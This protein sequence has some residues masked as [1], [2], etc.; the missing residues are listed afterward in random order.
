MTII[1]E[2][3]RGFVKS[4]SPGK[5]STI[6]PIKR[7][8][9][10]GKRG[11][12]VFE[13]GMSGGVLMASPRESKGSTKTVVATHTES[14]ASTSSPQE[15]PPIRPPGVPRHHRRRQGSSALSEKANHI[16]PRGPRRRSF[17]PADRQGKTHCCLQE[18]Q[19]S[20]NRHIK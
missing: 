3:L 1:A 18:W 5:T 4:D 10:L 8:R 2:V 13:R 11:Y 19:R 9:G 6:L 20:H 12:N 15:R 7:C 14:Y 16:R 17:L